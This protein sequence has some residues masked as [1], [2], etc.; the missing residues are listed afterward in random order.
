MTSEVGLLRGSPPVPPRVAGPVA[1]SARLSDTAR[2]AWARLDAPPAGRRVPGS[3]LVLGAGVLL[4]TVAAT[5]SV[6]TGHVFD[7]SEAMSHLAVAR[8]VLDSHSPGTQQLGSV[9]PPFPHLLVLPLVQSLWLWSTGIAGAIVGTLC[10]GSAS[11]SVYRIVARLGGGRSARAAAL[12]V[13]WANPAYLYLGT[14]ALTEPVLVATSLATVAGLVGWASAARH[15]SGGEL[16]V[17]AGLPAAAGV[18]TRHEGWALTVA[19]AVY[20]AV[21]ATRRG[22]RPRRWLVLVASYLAPS[23]AAI[24]SWLA[25]NYAMYA[26][27]LDFARGPYSA[28]SLNAWYRDG[29]FMATQRNLGLSLDVYGHG[30]LE[31]AGVVCLLA[32]LGGLV[33][34]TLSWGLDYRSLTLW[35]GASAPAF[36]V[37]G[38]WAG[39]LMM[40]NDASIPVGDLNNRLAV[41]ALPW[42]ALL[43]GALV[44]ALPVRR[45]PVRRLVLAGLLVG[46]VL[47]NLWWAADY[48]QRNGVIAEAAAGRRDGADRTAASIWVRDH[49]D[50]GGLL[51]DETAVPSAPQIGIPLVEH[52]NRA[53]E[54]FEAGLQNPAQLARWVLMHR[55]NPDGAADRTG[56][57]LVAAAF[58]DRP[59]LLLDYQQVY[60]AGELVVF[61]RIDERVSGGS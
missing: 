7:Y 5:I 45:V 13:L 57:D 60:A 8:R 47:Q 58:R 22:I 24:V 20:L 36:L 11:V 26:D 25:Y 52:V 35:V 23:A 16:A 1:P 29:G 46:L 33:V 54:Q 17:F 31:T 55:P 18:L 41:I 38:L 6:R 59:H 37:Y 32:A 30:V 48:Q 12:L 44:T 39:Q 43:V 14:T 34:A 3:G 49:Y 51:V 21:V 15:L 10:L 53:A 9:W 50:G 40:R 27:P 2:R 28:T 4:G 42:C 56:A 61:R 19:G